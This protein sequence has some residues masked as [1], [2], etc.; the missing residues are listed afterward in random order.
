MGSPITAADFEVQN[1]SGDVC[2]QI[3]K[4]LEINNKLKTWF[5]WAFDTAT[6]DAT[7]AFLASVSAGFVPVGSLL[8]MPLPL[9]ATPTGYLPADG[10]SVSRTTYAALFAKYGV[11]FGAGDGS[12]TFTL[13]DLRGRFVLGASDT[14][15]ALSKG[16]EAN[17]TLT[18]AE[19]PDLDLVVKFEN[20]AGGA[21]YSHWSYD[22]GSAD[23]TASEPIGIGPGTVNENMTVPQSV[24][25]GAHNNMPP[26]YSGT[27]MVK[28]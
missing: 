22:S 2:E 18:P 13:P 26:Y 24:S 7:S 16:G 9:S 17:H 10:R 8:W 19:I 23:G 27:W 14:Y 21:T 12:T 5:E 28:T 4:L 3:K 15:A 25:G 20:A 6:G 1:F 11:T